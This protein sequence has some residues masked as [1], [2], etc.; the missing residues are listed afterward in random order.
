MG[1]SNI[2]LKQI[3][4]L[5]LLSLIWG[6]SF[7]LVKRG[8]LA[9]SPLELAALRV[10]IAGL[11]FLPFFI[12]HVKKERVKSCWKYL[13]VGLTGTAIPA[14]CFALAQTQISSSVAG[15]MNALTPIFTIL[16]G[17]TFYKMKVGGNQI[18]GVAL[19]L[20]GAIA[21]IL[22]GK[23]SSQSNNM[24]FAGFVAISSIL[25][26]MNLNFVKKHFQN[27][28]SIRLSAVSFV[29]V[30]IPCLAYVGWSDIPSIMNTDAGIKALGYVAIL[31][32][33]STMVALIIFYKL[34]Q[35]TNPVF[36]SSVSYVV[37]IVALLWGVW[38]GEF[39]GLGHYI[40]LGLI[41]LAVYL[42]RKN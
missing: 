26:A 42:I 13:I 36:A 15:I 3:L 14:F 12:F 21:L 16:I 9:Y 34:V 31:S 39:I 2:G 7:I 1:D 41:L 22:Q 25:Y 32:I 27:E 4:T 19:G 5:V 28:N 23:D 20:C 29:L 37:P 38:D 30:S 24:W 33:M 40:S 17:I 18:I 6:T 11:F 10:S 35:T 8:L